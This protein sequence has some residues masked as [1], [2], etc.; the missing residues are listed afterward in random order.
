M[1]IDNCVHSLF[2]VSKSYADL[3]VQEYGKNV[4]LKTVSFRGGCI[5]GP[6][7]SGAKL[8]G[9]LSY[10]VKASLKNKK[11]SHYNN[12]IQIYT[13]QINRLNK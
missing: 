5:T 6:N 11:Y 8:H 10:L 3:A 12:K 9:F 2:G 13:F 4:G 1:S 7:H